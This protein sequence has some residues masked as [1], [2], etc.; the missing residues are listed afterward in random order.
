MKI[1]F[2]YVTAISTMHYFSIGAL[3]NIAGQTFQIDQFD[4]VLHTH[5]DLGYGSHGL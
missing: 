1:M 4:I 2:S 3:I 5:P